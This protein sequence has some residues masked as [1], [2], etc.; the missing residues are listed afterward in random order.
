MAG[1]D[2]GDMSPRNVAERFRLELG[3]LN[4]YLEQV[5][6]LETEFLVLHCEMLLAYARE[7][8]EDATAVDLKAA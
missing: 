8:H 3:L 5:P 1:S 4:E 2:N 7:L 6:M